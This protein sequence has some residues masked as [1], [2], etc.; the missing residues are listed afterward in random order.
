MICVYSFLFLL[1]A[2]FVF[3]GVTT[4]FSNVHWSDKFIGVV[5]LLWGLA[6]F[7]NLWSLFKGWLIIRKEIALMKDEE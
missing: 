5:G 3:F 1:W 4:I 6:G 7:W 2:W